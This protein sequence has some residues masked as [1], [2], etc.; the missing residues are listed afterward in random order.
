[1]MERREK[2]MD[3]YIIPGYPFTSINIIG[4]IFDN[5]LLR[6]TSNHM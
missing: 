3:D 2:C 4:C 1:M 6:V 5:F